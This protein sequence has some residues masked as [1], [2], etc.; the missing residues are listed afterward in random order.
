M[1]PHCFERDTVSHESVKGLYDDYEE[2]SKYNA[3]E[4]VGWDFLNVLL[5]VIC[6][7]ARVAPLL[8]EN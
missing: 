8:A 2:K 3:C 6:Y 4:G 5:W 1:I 7:C